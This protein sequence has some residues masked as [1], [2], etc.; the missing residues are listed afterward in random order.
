MK[1]LLISL[2][3]IGTVVGTCLLAPWL[4]DAFAQEKAITAYE[5]RQSEVT[6]GCGFRGIE[7]SKKVPFGREITLRA[8]CSFE[9]PHSPE[10]YVT[11]TIFVSFLGIAS[12][13][14][15]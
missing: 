11:V 12:S 5:I 7:S 15:K 6:D 4:T 1:K 3:L 9:A 8:H 14:F 10:K 2:I 13:T